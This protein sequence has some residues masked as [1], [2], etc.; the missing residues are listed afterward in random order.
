MGVGVLEQMENP[1]ESEMNFYGR[2]GIDY[3]M[4]LMTENLSNDA[5]N[6]NYIIVSKNMSTSTSSSEI[7][8]P[9]INSIMKTP[10]PIYNRYLDF[11]QFIPHKDEDMNDINYMYEMNLND[12]Q[13]TSSAEPVSTAS[14]NGY[15]KTIK[16]TEMHDNETQKFTCETC[17]RKYITKSNLEKHMRSHDLFMCIICMKVRKNEGLINAAINYFLYFYYTQMFGNPEELRGHD[18]FKQKASAK[19]SLLHCSICWK[20]LSNAWSLNRHMKIHRANEMARA[21]GSMEK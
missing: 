9:P 7:T 8:L 10:S 14:S 20:V 13:S 21:D 12:R 3:G 1:K 2:N 19:K 4:N 11:E 6:N 5:K 15:M 17:G 16:F 18:C